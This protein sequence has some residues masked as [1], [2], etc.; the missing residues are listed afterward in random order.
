[1]VQQ[2]KI[3]I[4]FSKTYT[5]FYFCF[6]CIGDESYLYMNKAEICKFKANYNTIWYNFCL[7]STSKDFTKDEQSMISLNG[8]VH[9]FSVDHSSI[10][11][12]KIFNIHPYLMIKNNTK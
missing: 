9:D 3:S 7:G 4:N 12:E 2:K 8:T 11:K 6:H 10:K 1:M 5:N